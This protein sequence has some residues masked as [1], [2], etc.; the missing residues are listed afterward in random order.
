MAEIKDLSILDANNTARWPEGQSVMSLNDAGRAD[1]GM[2]ARWEKDTN[3]SLITAGSATAYTLLSN[4]SISSY[5][6]GLVMKVRAHVANTGAATL[7]I[8]SIGAKDLVR[9][10]GD[11]LVN[12]DISLH[13]P[14]EIMYNASTDKF[15]CM[16]I[17]A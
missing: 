11:A 5:Y 16:G 1:E 2:I 8:N 12:G 7:N 13:Q 15:H 17:T 4:R 9:M 14:L 10:N 3:Y 6:S